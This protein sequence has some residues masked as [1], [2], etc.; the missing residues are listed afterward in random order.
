ML[1][2]VSASHGTVSAIGEQKIVLQKENDDL[3]KVRKGWFNSHA[4]TDACANVW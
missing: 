1:T 4:L 3:Q 2:N